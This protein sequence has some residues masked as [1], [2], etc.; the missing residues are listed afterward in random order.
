MT[1]AELIEELRQMPSH[2][3]VER[4]VKKRSPMGETYREA[5]LLSFARFEGKRVVLEF[6]Q[7]SA[8]GDKVAL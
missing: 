7:L 4:I 5:Q 2:V 6:T 3:P 1:V 8:Y